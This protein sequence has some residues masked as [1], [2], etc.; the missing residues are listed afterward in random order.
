MFRVPCSFC[1]SGS[2]R[3]LLLKFQFNF[4][5]LL[6]I[7]FENDIMYWYPLL[8]LEKTY[9]RYDLDIVMELK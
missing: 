4:N 2:S 9:E 5:A 1:N 6:Q 8:L 3:I 7:E